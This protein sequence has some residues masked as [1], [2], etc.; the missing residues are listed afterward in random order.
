MV[1][2]ERIALTDEQKRQFYQDGFIKLLGIVPRER[3]DAALRAI[4]AALGERGMHPDELPT[5]R[6]RS[7]CPE[8][9]DAPAITGLLHET[10]LGAWPSRRSAPAGSARSGAAR[11]R[12]AS[13]C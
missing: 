2:T 11:S 3:V 4:N 5:L 8:I 9:Q 13:R 10:P 12:C 6:A 1:T 7:Y